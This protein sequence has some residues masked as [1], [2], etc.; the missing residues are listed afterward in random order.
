MSC[1]PTFEAK[2]VEE[3]LVGGGFLIARRACS[4]PRRLAPAPPAATR[5][6]GACAFDEACRQGEG[7]AQAVAFLSHRRAALRSRLLEIW[8][9]QDEGPQGVASRRRS[10]RAARLLC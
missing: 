10:G 3:A 9:P 4:A 5:S 1:K 2:W 7:P 6:D 8:R